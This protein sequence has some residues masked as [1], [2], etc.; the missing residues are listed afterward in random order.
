[1]VITKTELLEREV[2][3]SETI[4]TESVESTS[5]KTSIKVSQDKEEETE[6]REEEEIIERT[7]E[8]QKCAVLFPKIFGSFTKSNTMEKAGM[9]PC[10]GSAT[11]VS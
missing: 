11:G 4:I 6:I 8:R 7:R 10:Q 2:E 9:C 5:T 1:M 3:E